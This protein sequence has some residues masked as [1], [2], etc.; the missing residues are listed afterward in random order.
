MYCVSLQ[1]AIWQRKLF[2]NVL[3]KNESVW[4]I[5]VDGSPRFKQ[6]NKRVIRSDNP[7][8]DYHRGGYMIKGRVVKEVEQWTKNN[9]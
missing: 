7:I 2:L 3:E 1:A 4:Q 9:W 8:I 5:E 6:F